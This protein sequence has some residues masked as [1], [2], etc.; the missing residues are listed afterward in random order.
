MHVLVTGGTGNVGRAA[1]ARLIRSGHTVRVIGRR[2][3][4]TLEQAEYQSCDINDYRALC[5]QL[6]GMEAVVHLAAIPHPSLAAG[7]EIFRV[8][9][10]GTFNVYRA[11]AENGIR[12]VLTASSINALGYNFGTRN[13]PLRYFPMDEEHPSFTTDPYSFSKQILEEIAAYFWRR[14]GISGICMRLPAVYEATSSERGSRA[15]VV[16]AHDAYTALF[17]L[18]MAERQA[19]AQ[20]VI[21]RFEA[22]RLDR[23]W[24]APH[25]RF[26]MDQPDAGLMFGRS[27]FWTSIDA[28]DSAQAIEKGLLADYDGSH[29]LYIND[30]HNFAGVETEALASLFFP[31]VAARTRTLVGTQSLVSIDKARALIGFEPQHSIQ[32]R[33]QG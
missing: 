24:E 32:R 25:G 26:G 21:G 17:D 3:G 6:K 9:C 16:R 20:Q 15:F 10:S 12:R 22:L 2:A 11:A 5:D 13:F 31:E 7:Q 23:A 4:V 27:N 29:V 19:R 33:F 8:N 18:P 1:V 28:E 14:E 30:S